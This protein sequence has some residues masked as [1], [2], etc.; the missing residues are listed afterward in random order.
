MNFRT[1]VEL[2]EK[3]TEIRHSDRMMLFGSC[4]A[5][6]IGKL[7]VENKFRCDVN[8]FGILY[9]PLSVSE[10][11]RRI[12]SGRLYRSD[13][14]FASG[15]KWHS[16]MHHSVFSGDSAEECLEHINSR[17]GQASVA[18]PRLD[19]LIITWGT[20]WVYI[21]KETGVVVGNCHK[22]PDRLFER[23]LL[24]VDEIVETYAGLL[25]E[26]RRIN[27]RVKVLFTVSPIRH[28]KDGMHG[29][30][31]SKSV[32]MLAV[33]ALQ[34]RCKD[35]YYFPSYEIMMDELRDYRFYADD[36][37]H[38]SS[39]AVGYLWECFDKTY[40]GTETRQAIKGWEEIK[41]ALGH[42]PFDAHSDAYRKFLTQIVLKIDQL[43]EKFPYFDLQK[44]S[45]ECQA[46]LKI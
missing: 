36:M 18:L 9:N 23:R 20:A 21:R 46:R 11:I 12:L 19:W 25:A 26:V 10:A 34:H 38:P 37:V 30:Q 24:S 44:E 32:L 40:F 3:E 17:L 5:E 31:I 27:P 15:G 16:F 28:V 7:L 41:K 6:N 4:F 45:E 22:Q 2:P 29:N 39:M 1:Q 8:P 42:K 35:C 14:L 33:D 43:K 13:E